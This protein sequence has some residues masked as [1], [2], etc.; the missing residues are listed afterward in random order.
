MIE[1]SKGDL[2][3]SSTLRDFL[4]G[5]QPRQRRTLGMV[6]ALL[7]RLQAVSNAHPEWSRYDLLTHLLAALHLVIETDRLTGGQ[8]EEQIVV[9]L[10]GLV[11]IENPDDEPATHQ[12]IAAAVVDVL[13]NARERRLRLRDRYLH[14]ADG[15]V[16]HPE[17]S[18]AFVR[19][20]GDEDAA[21]PTLR[22]TPEA[23]N[24]F[25]NLYQFDPSDRAAAERYRSERMLER[26]E[27]DEVLTSVERRATAVHG[28]RGDLDR[29]ARRIVYNVRDVDYVAEVIP[30]LDEVLDMVSEQVRAEEKFAEAVDEVIHH[31]APDLVRLQRI[32]TSL[33]G[34]VRGLGQLQSRA[35]ETRMAF[36]D[37]QDRQL[38]TYRRIT[39]NPQA[40][41]LQP[42]LLLPPTAVL[43][44]LQG[45]LAVWLGPKAPRVLHLGE[46][47]SRTTPGEPK[48][49]AGP[50]EDPFLL[51]RRRSEDDT[52]P[53]ALQAA[54]VDLLAQ[55][56]RPT[57][58]STLL[59]QIAASPVADER[60]A[61]W[62]PWAL[63][64]T[65]ANAY[66]HAGTSERPGAATGFDHDRLV[67]VSTGETLRD[68]LLIWGDDPMLV[69]RKA[70]REENA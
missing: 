54:V 1:I 68:G 8:T 42:L 6:N 14:V 25:Q 24:V 51:G 18:F 35:L 34:L 19:A 37:E 28:L 66:G 53:R 69:P 52:L 48:L 2:P 11:A 36:E 30:R 31:D 22:A 58:L 4:R 26:A 44:M 60:L 21:E 45:T 33:R 9:E 59:A 10:S 40:Q 7:A 55:V 12:A 62:L 3:V 63:A 67:V 65:V 70:R 43:E 20:V 5:W 13:T 46:L 23:V 64:V 29:L 49:P 27:Y 56:D 17:Q 47:V 39:I 50:S 38:F 16:Q 41:L 57:K 32:S 15:A 61:D